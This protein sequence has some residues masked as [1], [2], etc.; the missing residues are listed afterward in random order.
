MLDPLTM[1]L[2][3]SGVK[4]VFGA[5]Q[6]IK[7]SQMARNTQRPEYNIPSAA[8]AY[9]QNAQA[10]A[11]NQRLP[12]QSAIEGQIQG[13]TASG[14]RN[15]TE[16]GNNP[17]SIMATIAALNSNQNNAIVN[18]GTE[19]AQMQQ[20]NQRNLGQAQQYMA[21]QEQQ[22]FDYNQN[23]P[24]QQKIQAAM[25][26]KGA[27]IQNTFGALEN[28]V[29]AYTKSKEPTNSNSGALTPDQL[30]TLKSLGII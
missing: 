16:A 22:A 10:M 19:A 6:G 8:T 27:G 11:Q 28:A 17:A 5:Y 23:Q 18:V 12:G 7:G 3:L 1:S 30:A 21:G 26:L 24:Y 25:A 14:I 2:M 15:A 9:L 13:A 4:G 20:Q 29:G